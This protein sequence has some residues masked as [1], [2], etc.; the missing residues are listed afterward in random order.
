[1]G[2]LTIIILSI[3]LAMDAF[4]AAITIGISNDNIKL[5]AFRSAIFFGFFQF[6]MLLIGYYLGDLFGIV[7]NK[8]DHW[9]AFLLLTYI[10]I[11]MIHQINDKVCVI[12]YN[13]FKIL[14]LAL[15]TS[16]DAVAA[17]ITISALGGIIINAALIVGFI[18]FILSFIGVYLGSIFKHQKYSYFFDVL[19]GLILIGIGIK[20]LIEHLFVL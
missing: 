20:I 18:T 2:I 5:N 14:T 19:G 12:K 1:M 9:I 4:A 13:L 15:A 16:I 8:Y 10:G 17:G 11:D 3:G 6:A 7:I